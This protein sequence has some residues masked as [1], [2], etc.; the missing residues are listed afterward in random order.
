MYGNINNINVY[1]MT[2]MT[3]NDNETCNDMANSYYNIMAN[4]RGN[5][6]G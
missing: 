6:A 2:V 3:N 5:T 1:V 4:I